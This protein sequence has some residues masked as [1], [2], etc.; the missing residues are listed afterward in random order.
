MGEILHHRELLQVAVNR[1]TRSLENYV[2]LIRFFYK[3]NLMKTHIKHINHFQRTDKLHYLLVF[4]LF[5]VFI[6]SHQ[7]RVYP[8]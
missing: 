5:D 4:I 7:S 1:T 3:Y 6:I 8:R 2:T